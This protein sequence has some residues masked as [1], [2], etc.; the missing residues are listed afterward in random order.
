[1]DVTVESLSEVKRKIGVALPPEDVRAE[2]DQAYRGLQQHARIKGFRPGKVPRTILERYYGDQVR[3]EVIGK[4][5]QES[6]ARALEQHH[7]HAVA[8]PEIVAEEVRPGEGLRYSAT[9]EIKPTF[10]VTGYETLE[11]ERSVEPVSDEMVQ[12]QLERLRESYAQMV[13]LEDRDVVE[14]GDLVEIG[15]TGVIEGRALPGASA[16]GRVIEIGAG[17]FPPP[18]EEQLVGKRVGESVHVA[19][20]YPEHHHSREVAGKTVTFRVEIKAVGR[21]ELPVLDD[22]FA[23]DHGECGSLAE[24]REKVRGGLAAAAERDA[25]ERM[26]AAVLEK[27]VASNPIEVPD[28]LVERRLDVMLREVG[29]HGVDARG[30]PDLE[31]RL[32]DL[33]AELRRRARE[34]VHSGLLLERLAAQE[35]IEVSEADVEARIAEVLRAA[36]RDRERLAEIYRAP[37]A[38]RELRDR[39]AQEKALE[40]L[41][42]RVT[43]REAPHQT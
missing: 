36:P 26:R 15:Y 13:R 23:K 25:D 9:I 43:I 7:L 19:V 8:R 16:Q 32:D 30:N 37:E 41:A 40:W 17:T 33:R 22:D 5:I 28:A 2:L 34:S 38:R 1:V 3:S 12:A 6:Y 29:A 20:P 10:D 31:K 42:G 18:F 11:V 35:G 39:L 27:L 24:L 21:K 4:L 14:Q